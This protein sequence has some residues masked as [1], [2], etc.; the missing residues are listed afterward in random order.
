M[1][2]ANA[3]Q[4]DYDD[5]EVR[6]TIRVD[7]VSHDTIVVVEGRGNLAGG[8]AMLACLDEIA[9]RFG[10]KL[11]SRFS[12]DVSRVRGAPMRSQIQ[13]GRWFFAHRHI[14]S[15]AAV[16]GAGPV[17]RRLATAVCAVA[18]IRNF[19]FFTDHGE[20]RAWLDLQPSHAREPGPA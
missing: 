14:V 7:A 16:I 18:G 2:S 3:F 1:D 20:A 8:T 12:F 17:E 5:G 19:R 4:R 6:F 11:S 13:F 15:G 9:A 10:S